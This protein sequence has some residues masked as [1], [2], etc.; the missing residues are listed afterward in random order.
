M[1]GVVCL[2]GEFEGTRIR[3]TNS[4]SPIPRA[5]ED[6]IRYPKSSR[7]SGSKRAITSFVCII[8]LSL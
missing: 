2:E 3:G 8:Y 6:I 7:E 5:R 1:G 4:L